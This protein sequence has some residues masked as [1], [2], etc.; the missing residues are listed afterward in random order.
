MLFS[1]PLTPIKGEPRSGGFAAL[2]RG[3]RPGFWQS[4]AIDA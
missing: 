4:M 2:D 3:E 1:R